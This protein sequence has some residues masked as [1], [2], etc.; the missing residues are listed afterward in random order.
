[1]GKKW[2]Q[3]LLFGTALLLLLAACAPSTPQGGTGGP[4]SQ[5]S[6]QLSWVHNAEFVGFYEAL[7]HGY[8]T[9]EGLQ[10]ELING[11]YDDSG[12]YIDPVAEVLNGNAQFGVTGADVLLTERAKGKPVVA[13]AA[14]FQRNPVTLISLKEKGIVRPQDLIGHRVAMDESST[15]GICYDA[16]LASQDIDPSQIDEVLRTDYTLDALFEGAV[17]VTPGFINNDGVV[18]RLRSGDNVNFILM[19]DYGVELYS[20]VIFT[21][22][23]LIAESPELVEAFVR[24]TI[25]GIQSAVDEPDEAAQY[26]VNSYGDY[27]DESTQLSSVRASV[28]LLVPA[29]S[30]PG[31]MTTEA[32]ER[33]HQI[34]LD[35]G[36]LSEPIDVDAAYTLT[37]LNEIH[38]E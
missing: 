14:I 36:I 35:Q 9:Q 4:T 26:I 1:M 20:N 38:S 3:I 33:A 22:E 17:D 21:T 18:A 25:Q 15:V 12:A 34:L 30:K 31:A 5:I 24:G 11:G 2:L 27:V 6:V 37:F 23:D 13:V 7:S 29:G 19:S 28:P 32:W 8:Y 10:V 16:L